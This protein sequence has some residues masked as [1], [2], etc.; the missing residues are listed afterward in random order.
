MAGEAD[1]EWR[2]AP[3]LPVCC[4]SGPLRAVHLSRHTW[5]GGLGTLNQLIRNSCQ[6]LKAEKV[7]RPKWTTPMLRLS[8]ERDW[9]H[10]PPPTS[11]GSVGACC[12]GT[13]T[14]VG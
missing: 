4:V 5:P 1:P 13:Q 11:S 9:P 10:P 14:R 7:N 6:P 2:M 12:L 3:G 8:L